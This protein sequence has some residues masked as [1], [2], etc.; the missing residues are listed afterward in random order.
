MN[1]P[2]VLRTKNQSLAAAAKEV[3]KQQQQ[4]GKVSQIR[5][6]GYLQQE[7]AKRRSVPADSVDPGKTMAKHGFRGSACRLVV[8]EACIAAGVAS[9]NGRLRPGMSLKKIAELMAAI[10]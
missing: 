5:A 10:K 7:I 3:K 9:L 2:S 1:T 8:N 6:L 4:G